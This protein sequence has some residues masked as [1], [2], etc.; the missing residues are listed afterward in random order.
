M[1]IPQIVTC[2]VAT[3][4]NLRQHAS[5]KIN[6][7]LLLGSFQLVIAWSAFKVKLDSQPTTLSDAIERLL[8][9]LRE[10]DKRTIAAMTE[11][12]LCDL[13]FSLGLLIRNAWLHQADSDLLAACGTHSS[14]EASCRVIGALWRALQP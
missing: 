1:V 2:I 14:D 5:K 7:P 6:L 10:E 4:R 12:D 13:H 8:L 9:I 11:E 3:E